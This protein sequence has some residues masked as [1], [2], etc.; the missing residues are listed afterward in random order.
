[1]TPG[2]TSE[3][4]P[5][6]VVTRAST[7]IGHA[8]AREFAEQGFDVVIAAEVE[9]L[10]SG[11]AAAVLDELGGGGVPVPADLSTTEGVGASYRATQIGRSR[12]W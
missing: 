7:G 11:A 2:L 3:G 6:G 9:T 4:R 10:H 1:M 8:L 12:R 5:R